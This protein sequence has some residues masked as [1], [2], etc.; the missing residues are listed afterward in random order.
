[1]NKHQI[2]KN[3][4]LLKRNALFV[5]NVIKTK[6]VGRITKRRITR[7]VKEKSIID[8]VIGCEDMVQL[9]NS[10]TIDKEKKNCVKRFNIKILCV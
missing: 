5:V 4:D 6:C 1:M 3:S 2:K 10:L 9:I 7:K 8:F